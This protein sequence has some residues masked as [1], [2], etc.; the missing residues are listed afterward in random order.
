MRTVYGDH[1]RFEQTY[2]STFKGMYFT[3][4][5]ARPRFQKGFLRQIFSKV[6]IFAQPI[7]ETI[8]ILVSLLRQCF[9]SFVFFHSI[10][11]RSVELSSS[12]ATSV[13]HLMPAV[14]AW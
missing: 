10:K 14:A 12:A 2:F 3:S 4:D 8:D 1:E 5:G 11:I 9:V 6:V 7:C 13:R